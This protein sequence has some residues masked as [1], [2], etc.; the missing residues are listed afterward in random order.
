MHHAHHVVVHYSQAGAYYSG[1]IFAAS[2][3]LLCQN[4][5]RRPIAII[6]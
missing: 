2:T 3:A 6:T 1:I 4:I 5:G